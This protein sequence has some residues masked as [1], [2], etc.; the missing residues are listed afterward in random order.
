MLG[1]VKVRP[2]VEGDISW[3]AAEL[4]EFAEFAS[5]RHSLIPS[6]PEVMRQGFNQ[7]VKNHIFLVAERDLVPMGFVAGVVFPH[8]FNPEIL[9]LQEVFW[10]VMK[11]YRGSRAALMLLDAFIAW[12]RE[13]VDW[14]FFSM[15]PNTPAGDR[16]LLKRGFKLQEKTYLLEV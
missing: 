1:S 10:W 3:I 8:L 11:A 13:S 4:G 16:V 12:G 15:Q 14:I 5:T 9:V 7:F 6:D 2:A